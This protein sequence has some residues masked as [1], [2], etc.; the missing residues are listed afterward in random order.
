MSERPAER[1]LAL[2]I[3]RKDWEL[4]ALCVVLQAVEMVRELPPEAADAMLQLLDTEKGE[5]PPRRRKCRE[6]R[7]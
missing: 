5:A 6:R 7:R 2:A 4:A 1:I 3:E